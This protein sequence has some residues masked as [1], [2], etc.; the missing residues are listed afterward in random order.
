M[1][2]NI[3]PVQ[4]NAVFMRPLA[5][6]VVAGPALLGVAGVHPAWA[7]EEEF[8]LE[9]VVTGL[10]SPVAIEAEPGTSRLFVVERAGRIRIVVDG[11]VT[12][13]FLDIRSLVSTSG[14]QGLLGLAFHPAYESNGKLYVN[15]TNNSGDTRV[16]EYTANI[17]RSAAVSSS[18][19]TL[20]AID[21]PAT[22]HNAGDLV[23]GPDGY[24]Y[25][26]TG[27]G[28]GVAGRSNGQDTGTLLGGL[29][30][31]D[32][33]SGKAPPD[34]PFVGRPGADLLWA[35]GLRNPWRFTIDAP[36]GNVL[37]GEVGQNRYEEID[38]TNIDE[39]GVNFGWARLELHRRMGPKLPDLRRR[40]RLAHQLG[41]TRRDGTRAGLLRGG[42]Q[43]RAAADV[44]QGDD[45]SPGRAAIL[46]GP[47]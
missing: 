45:L 21:Q 3:F 19:R 44:D 30:R 40:R 10:N 7:V 46:G 9:E 36:T 42:C 8:D 31:I 35:Y 15:Y 12:A 22:N 32:V 43:G 20:V 18:A 5:V 1:F 25:I 4:Y 37:I 33:S 28:G 16:V 11:R 29:L 27:D 24:L 47:L 39:G 23:F 2:G 6:A 41:G 14:E 26:S 17:D 38:L 34:N 13:T